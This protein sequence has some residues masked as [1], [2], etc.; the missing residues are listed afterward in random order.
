MNITEYANSIF[1]QPW[2]L[3]V[4]APNAWEEICIKNDNGEVI[5]RQAIV[6]GRN[7]IFMPKL[8]QTLGIWLADEVR[9]NYGMQKEL[10]SELLGHFKGNNILIRLAPEN[11]YVLPFKWAGYVIEPKFT[12]RINDLTNLELLYSGFNKTAKKN[13]KSARNKVKI[14]EDL[15]LDVLWEM[16]NKTFDAQKRRNPMAKDVIYRIIDACEKNGNGKYFGAIDLEGNIHSCAYFVFDEKV[17]YY[18]LGATD[19]K[20]RSSGA[21]SL[22]LWEGIQFAARHSKIFDFEGSMVEGI[23]NFF[24]QFNNTCTTYYEVRKQSLFSEI[25]LLLK[26]KVKKWIGYK[27]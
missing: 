6:K 14:S 26:P 20:Y 16:L 25:L 19:S 2:W 17:C 5:A 11:E 1:E 8:T 10:I 3:D 13:I 15:D 27:E 18:L 24:R 7:K 12:Y 21:Q 9:K 4:V 22:I 23:E